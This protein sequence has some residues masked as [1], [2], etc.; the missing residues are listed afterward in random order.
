MAEHLS[1]LRSNR[2][3]LRF[4]GPLLDET[5]ATAAGSLAVVEAARRA[6]AEDYIAREA[7]CR[8]GMFDSVEITRFAST[9]MSRQTLI[10]PDPERPLFVC[11]WLAPRGLSHDP[12]PRALVTVPATRVFE[13]GVL[14]SDDGALGIG[15]LFIVESGDRS[16]AE[17]TIAAD[18]DR[19]SAAR[20]D[21]FVSRWR[22]GEALSGANDAQG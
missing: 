11:R 12:A 13:G 22:F 4:A 7:F 15:G 19:A 10:T 8:A 21:S 20:A 16:G 3:R 5:G 18:A 14:L 6:D 1:Y 17:K 9:T 2:Y